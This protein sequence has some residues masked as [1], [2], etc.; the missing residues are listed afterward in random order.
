MVCPALAPA[1]D[2]VPDE[3]E[4]PLLHE[5][6]ES[7]LSRRGPPDTASPGSKPV[8]TLD[9]LSRSTLPLLCTLLVRNFDTRR[10]EHGGMVACR[11]NTQRVRPLAISPERVHLEPESLRHGSAEK[12]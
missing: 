4:C 6:A 10:R 3:Y 12:P 1:H 11:T 8:Q 2:R 9:V 7:P 5:P